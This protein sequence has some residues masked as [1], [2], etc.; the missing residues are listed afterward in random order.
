MYFFGD[1]MKIKID[2]EVSK[3]SYELSK[4]IA[5]LIASIKLAVADGWQPG[6]DIPLII[7]EVIGRLVPAL[8]GV[9]KIKDEIKE[10]KEAAILALLLPVVE[11]I[12]SLAS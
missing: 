4:G 5:D 12:N 1:K 8:Q 9:E 11:V 3:E 2:V 10:D 7:S 6:K